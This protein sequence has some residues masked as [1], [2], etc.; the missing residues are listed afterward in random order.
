MLKSNKWGKLGVKQRSK[1]ATVLAAKAATMAKGEEDFTLDQVKGDLKMTK[2]LTLAPFETTHVMTQSRVKGH[3]KRVNVIT[4]PQD[5]NFTP[6]IVTNSGYACLN[7]RS[8][9]IS[10]S[11]RNLTE[12]TVTVAK[13]CGG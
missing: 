12:R 1:L 13:D 7:P 5:K 11:L 6:D 8:N 10:V 4:E 9:R 3:R 2:A